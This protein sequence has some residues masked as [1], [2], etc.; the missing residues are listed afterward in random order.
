MEIANSTDNRI[1]IEEGKHRRRQLLQLFFKY[2]K[3]DVTIIPTFEYNRIL[4]E[5]RKLI[6]QMKMMNEMRQ[7]EAD[8]R[9]IHRPV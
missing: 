5:N 2:I 1:I 8:R 4:E 6:S 9:D 7:A 3:L